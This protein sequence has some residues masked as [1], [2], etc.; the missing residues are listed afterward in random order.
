MTLGQPYVSPDAPHEYER[1]TV[2][3]RCNWCF[4]GVG[5]SVHDAPATAPEPAPAPARTGD[6]LLTALYRLPEGERESALAAYGLRILREAADLCGV[7][8][9]TLTKRQ[10]I[11]AI[12]GNF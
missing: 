5:A 1:S 4:R 11:A 8:A 6:D 12:L 3:G 2:P 9:E 7:D 10:A